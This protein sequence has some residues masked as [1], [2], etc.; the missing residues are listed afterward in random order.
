MK[1]TN[2]QIGRAGELLVQQ[3][4][5][6]NG[7]ESSALTTDSGI[8][9][10][11]FSHRKGKAVTIQIKAN[12]AAK[13]GGGKGKL[14]LDW[15]APDN[16]PADV[17]A[18]VDLESNRIW[19]VKKS[20]LAKLAQQ[21]PQGRYHFFMAIDPTAKERKDGQLHHDYEFQKYLLE[22]RIHRLF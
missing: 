6:L 8:D 13:P 12:L 10:V 7:I 15:W 18:F 4:F 14:F 3:R 22:N 21:H 1:L 11:A 16:S 5:L 17:F 2:A 19:L 20:E 9:L